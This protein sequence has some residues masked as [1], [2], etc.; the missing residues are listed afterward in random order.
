MKRKQGEKYT[1]VVGTLDEES[2][3]GP[4]LDMQQ[5]WNH[6]ATKIGLKLACKLVLK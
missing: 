6:A 1:R 4:T 3:V 2:E 5:R